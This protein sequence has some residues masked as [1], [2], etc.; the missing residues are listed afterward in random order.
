MPERS[1]D[2]APAGEAVHLSES[3][4]RRLL[5]VG[6]TL[7][8]ELDLESVLDKVLKT[9]RDIT[10]A[11]YAAIGVLDERKEE[12][13]RFLFVGID[14]EQRRLIGP[15]PR[16][17]GVL[18]ELIRDPEPLLLHD[19]TEHPRSYGFP[20]GHPPMKTFLGVPIRVRGEAFGNLYLT[21]KDGGAD[22]TARDLES[23]VVLADWAA[24]AIDNARLY[25][26]LEGRRNEL[27]R[28]VRGLEATATVARSVG[29]ETDL[30]RVLELVAK[31]GRALIDARSLVVVLEQDGAPRVAAAAGEGAEGVVGQ[32]L[33]D[34]G[35]LAEAALG[36]AAS[37]RIADLSTRVGH[38]L[39]K[40]ADAATAALVAPLGFRAR[41]RG[42]LVAFDRVQAGPAFDADDEH[43]LTSFA[44]S[45]A[46][47][48]ATA[49]SVESERLRETIE[50]SE[51]ERRRWARELHDE[52]LQ[53]LG[54]LKVV[55]QAARQT[56]RPET[57]MDVVDGAVEQIDLSIRGLQGLITELRPAALDELGVGPALDALVK[58]T[59]AT[60]GLDIQARN[61]LAYET[62]QHPSRLTPELE[63]AVYRIV[64]ESLTNVVKHAQAEHVEI[65]L[66][67]DAD[68]V[69]VTVNDDGRGFD[70]SG[71]GEG[72]GLLGMR[73]RVSLAGGELVVDSSTDSG[74]AVRAT[75]PAAHIDL[76]GSERFREPA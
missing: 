70:P 7:V 4:L 14:E 37:E 35:T 27:E 41:A 33:A 3:E 20:A 29:V 1:G 21:D 30:E 60:S 57:L 2:M 56:E 45:A 15:L 75:L 71:S 38:G 63:S 46:I 26:S 28:A 65:A 42:L 59:S 48:I 51:Q 54:A 72:F 40:L 61:G 34:A 73:E 13:A 52:T 17:H 6:R 62:G 55:L 19:V 36:G 67:E 76:P 53:E 16:G 49:Q 47:A 64:Q 8:A 11:R 44:A 58:R 68:R 25:T 24:I 66:E 32:P 23:V 31:R 10:G 12:L 18:G 69:T 22:F 39:G 43:I 50:A 74:T 5:D 9:A